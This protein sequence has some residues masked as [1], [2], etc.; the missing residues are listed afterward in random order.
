[1]P[2]P[3]TPPDAR[4]RCITET[5]AGTQH[6]GCRKPGPAVGEL[7]I[8]IEPARAERR[9][10]RRPLIRASRGKLPETQNR[11][12]IAIV[13]AG[14]ELY[15][16]PGRRPWFR[17][18]SRAAINARERTRP[19]SSPEV[20][21]S[22]LRVVDGKPT[23]DVSDEARCETGPDTV[24]VYDVRSETRP[25]MG[26]FSVKDTRRRLS[27]RVDGKLTGS[28]GSLLRGCLRSL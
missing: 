25:A 22:L 14:Q 26:R 24:E 8:N 16:E 12:T 19:A 1:M 17:S 27:S 5:D 11:H 7:V 9:V 10:H 21:R 4:D 23:A 28:R 13:N 18:R 20:A 15:V 2:A 3:Q 6:R